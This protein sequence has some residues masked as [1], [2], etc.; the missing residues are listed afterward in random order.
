M[1]RAAAGVVDRYVR[2]VGNGKSYNKE[3]GS[4]PRRVVP[5]YL[6]DRIRVLAARAS[7]LRDQ[8]PSWLPSPG[9]PP[10]AYNTCYLAAPHRAHT[11]TAGCGR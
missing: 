8:R 11:A 10:C 5:S 1:R 3:V 6:R 4:G 2:T 9:S 7:P